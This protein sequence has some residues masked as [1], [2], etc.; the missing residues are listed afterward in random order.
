MGAFARPPPTAREVRKGLPAVRAFDG[1]ISPVIS[2]AMALLRLFRSLAALAALALALLIWVE[3]A[4]ARMAGGS[5]LASR[6]SRGFMSPPVTLAAAN[7]TAVLDRSA[8]AQFGQ[9]AHPGGSLGDLFNRPGLLG[10]FAAGFLGAGFLGL[11]FGHG[12]FGGL[13]GL[14]SFLG[15]VFQLVLVAMLGRLIWTWWRKGNTAAVAGFSPRQLADAY[16]RSRNEL[17]PDIGSPAIADVAITDHD[18]NFFERLF[19][20]IES[21]YGREDLD[22]LRS[23]VTPQMLSNFS[24]H[25]AHNA[26]RG[27]VN[28]VSGVTLL[29]GDIAEAWREGDTEYAAVAMHF[30]RLDRTVE[31]MSGRIVEGSATS[32]TEAAQVW[33]FA[34]APGRS[35]LLSAIQ[36]S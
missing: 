21:A 35:W 4:D 18:Y 13:G 32:P 24:E 26:D 16:G 14:A 33:T 1:T 19:G 29:K 2:P 12:L 28:M 10:G 6:G 23:R 15:L 3:D 11:L 22:A 36:S 31:R 7:R 5:A 34:R 30:S 27:V 8:T 20:E 17:L 25:L 9:P